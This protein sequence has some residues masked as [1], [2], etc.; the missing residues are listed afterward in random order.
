MACVR[1]GLPWIGIQ[2][3]QT[4]IKTVIF[5]FWMLIEIFISLNP[6][7]KDRSDHIQ[8]QK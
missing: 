8:I 6:G 5:I 1:E 3:S 4:D 2:I 7:S